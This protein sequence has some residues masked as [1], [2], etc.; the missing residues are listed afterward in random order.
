MNL[1][2]SDNILLD[3]FF[4]VEDFV[5][6][7]FHVSVLFFAKTVRNGF[8]WVFDLFVAFKIGLWNGKILWQFSIGLFH[9][10]VFEPVYL[11]LLL[12]VDLF[13]DVDLLLWTFEVFLCDVVGN[14]TLKLNAVG[15]HWPVIESFFSAS[16]LSFFGNGNSIF[17]Q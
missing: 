7:Q 15:V 16:H 5:Y 13:E 9:Q 12:A 17:S 1:S 8:D 6:D 2:W 11:L 3:D 4:Y 10:L 14:L